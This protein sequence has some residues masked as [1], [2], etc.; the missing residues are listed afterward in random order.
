M[1][2]NGTIPVNYRNFALP[3]CLLSVVFFMVYFLILLFLLIM[4]LHRP[5]D[6]GT[7]SQ[8]IGGMVLLVSCIGTILF[9][10]EMKVQ[11]FPWTAGI[12]L[13]ALFGVIIVFTVFFMSRFFMFDPILG[14]L[15]LIALGGFMSLPLGVAYLLRSFKGIEF[16]AIQSFSTKTGLFGLGIAVILFFSVWGMSWNSGIGI[17][18]AWAVL[19][20]IL[21]VAILMPVAG[22]MVFR[23][24]L[25]LTK[26][27]AADTGTGGAADPVP[28]KKISEVLRDIPRSM[29]PRVKWAIL[30]VTLLVLVTAGYYVYQ[31]ITDTTPGRT[32]TK[33]TL[34]APFGATSGFTSA[35]YHGKLWLIGGSGNARNGGTVWYTSDV[36]TW[37]PTT[38]T[39]MVPRSVGSSSAVFRDALWVIGG[40]DQGTLTPGNG[41]WYSGNGINW[42]EMQPKAVFP[43]RAWHSTVVFRDRIWVIGGNRGT[44]TEDLAGDVW[45]SDDGILWQQA[46]PSAEF[47]PR[48]DHS[49]FVYQDKMWVIGGRDN[50][51]YISDV[52]NSG[53]GIHWTQVTAS[54]PFSGEASFNAVVFDGRMWVLQTSEDRSENYSWVMEKTRGIWYSYD[55]ITWT[56]VMSS[57]EFFKEEYNGGQP[58]PIVFDNRLFVLQQYSRDTGIWYTRPGG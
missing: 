21:H 11:S 16:K 48:A 38:S 32:W 6:F 14:Y 39:D 43:P 40:S 26:I 53:D 1:D 27:S 25:T 52:W 30:I 17:V 31:D 49:S 46:T 23:L 42:S 3:L 10:R 33:V 44:E 41:I 47:S 54:A 35:E 8:L 20:G 22:V 55:G 50:T 45:Y 34:S 9:V 37:T 2:E 13:Y 19:C 57:P 28:R 7:V 18:L 51:G 15:G 5:W 58:Q 12:P 4:T 56:K 24:G 36:M 29:S